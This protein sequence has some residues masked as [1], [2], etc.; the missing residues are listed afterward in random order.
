VVEILLENNLPLTEESISESTLLAA[1][2]I[3]VTSST[4][5]IVP[6][7]ELDDKSVGTGASS[8]PGPLWQEI[9]RHYQEFKG[10]Y[11]N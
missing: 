3:W 5:E 4:W 10:A 2:E 11:C 6:V 1:D 8:G 7:L 9:N